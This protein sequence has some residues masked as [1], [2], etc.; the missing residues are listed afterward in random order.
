MIPPLIEL[1]R[2]DTIATAAI[3]VVAV[4]LVYAAFF[5]AGRLAA[6]HNQI[7]DEL[8]HLDDE[9]RYVT[10]RGRRDI[11]QCSRCAPKGRER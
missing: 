7:R 10:W 3:S 11:D 6:R 5:Y 9:R 2:A 8:R 1:S 4:L